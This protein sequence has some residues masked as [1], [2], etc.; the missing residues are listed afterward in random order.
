MVIQN[1]DGSSLDIDSLN[2]SDGMKDLL[3]VVD[4]DDDGVVDDENVRDAL[5]ILATMK[6]PT[7]NPSV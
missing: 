5:R 2:I 6:A 7:V 4:A 3:K 1:P